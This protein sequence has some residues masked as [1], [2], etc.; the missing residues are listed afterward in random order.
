M[1]SIAGINWAVI[2]SF[3]SGFLA[4]AC[5]V[6]VLLLRDGRRRQSYYR[7]FG[8]NLNEFMVVFSQG[9]DFLYGLPVYLT[10]PLFDKLKKGKLLQDVLNDKNW[11]R[12]KLF[13]DETEKHFDMPFVFSIVDD[14]LGDVWYELRCFVER[15]SSGEIHYVCLF[16]NITRELELHR[17]K[18]R[19]RDNLD[20]LL[21]NT[22]DFLWNFDAETREFSLLTPLIDEEHRVVPQSAGVVNLEKMMPESDYEMFNKVLNDRVMKYREYGAES[23][24]FETMKLRLYGSDEILVWYGFRGKLVHDENGKLQFRGTAR[25]M[26]MVLENP[27][28]GKTTDSMLSA[29]L[30]FPDV[31]IFWLDRNYKIQGCNQAFATDAKIA[32]LND[33]YGKS[34]DSVVGMK[35]LP[36]FNKVISEV[37]ANERSVTWK[38]SFDKDGRILMMNVTLVRDG[39]GKELFAMGT[40]LI[41]GEKD[42][43]DELN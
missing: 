6:L 19:V 34:L 29:V 27:N 43:K 25:K 33:I 5:V 11:G 8:N 14:V 17:E 20:S 39:S 9:L 4:V 28:L 12:L 10:D 1:E 21:Q 16:K 32:N 7:R 18:E 3:I 37:F 36:Y 13:L 24:T 30:S 26:D 22:G 2:L 40:Y 23:N 38:G 41:F 15:H 35:F 42:F 31:R